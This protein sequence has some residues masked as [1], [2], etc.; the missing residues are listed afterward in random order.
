MVKPFDLETH[1]LQRYTGEARLQRLLW[2]AGNII[3]GGSTRNS[4]INAEDG[5]RDVNTEEVA[6]RRESYE[7]ALQYAIQQ[8]NTS[9]YADIFHSWNQQKEQH[10]STSSN[11]TTT[12]SSTT[13]S[14]F[15][16]H[17]DAQWFEE[18]VLMNRQNR[19]VLYSRLQASQAHLNKDAI[20]VA[21]LA[22]A[23]FAIR[24]GDIN[25]AFHAALRAKDYC[26]TRNQ[27]TSVTL[28][29]L[30]F[31]IYLNNYEVIR[32]YVPRLEQ[33]IHPHVGGHTTN[34]SGGTNSNTS[35]DKSIH[36]TLRNCVL[37]A[38]GIEKLATFQYKAAADKFRSVAL[39]GMNS[40]R[41]LSSSSR[42]SSEATSSSASSACGTSL[43]GDI[44]IA[45]ASQASW[46]TNVL[47]PEDVALYAAFLTLAVEDNRH[48]V[49]MLAEDAEALE[50]VPQMKEVLIQFTRFAHYKVAF[51][52]LEKEIFPILRMDMYLSPH[53]VTLAQQ[54]RNRAIIQY[55]KPYEKIELNHMAEELGRDIIIPPAV[56]S[57]S[58]LAVLPNLN[59]QQRSSTIN[60]TDKSNS[61][62]SGSEL[63]LQTLI[64][65]MSTNRSALGSDTRIDLLTN[66]LVR[67]PFE[68]EQERF[69]YTS[70]RL[71]VV[72]KRV[73][74][75]AYSMLIKSSCAEY[76]LFVVDPSAE[77]NNRKSLWDDYAGANN[78]NV[79][80]RGE[81]RQRNLFSD[82]EDDGGE[83]YGEYENDASDDINNRNDGVYDDD[84][85][86]ERNVVVGS[87]DN[88][89]DNNDE[90]G[91][92]HDGDLVLDNT[93]G[94][95]MNPED[96]Y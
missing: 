32:D 54:I 55:W 5:L 90:H 96:L 78:R 68:P 45:T 57:E 85:D 27:T 31:A 36:I 84:H 46:D 62:S 44:A 77:K 88:D 53:L 26:T 15:V 86:D 9:R 64:Q 4:N 17:Y 91:Q 16:L 50:L 66:S 92:Y 76:N 29:I 65:L 1:V 69:M 34:V 60:K 79:S 35:L 71:N 61:L 48:V 3:I 37:I 21:Y 18:T 24:T 67:D 25:E 47:A 58:V 11:S 82:D 23:E 10:Q 7:A 38:S 40:S 70:N 83:E 72:S 6:L 43:S 89:N 73:L 13:A 42:P 59:K 33:T 94:D 87:D 39:S 41:D 14:D 63:L 93:G 56:S 51:A 12:Y 28:Q 75:D 8:N 30:M 2:I 52:I 22:V 80:A 19:D 81:G 49:M 95:E 20:R 74:N